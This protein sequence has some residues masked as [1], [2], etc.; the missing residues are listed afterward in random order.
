MSEPYSTVVWVS[1]VEG[2]KSHLRLIASECAGSECDHIQRIG[3]QAMTGIAEADR[4]LADQCWPDDEAD[5]QED[6]S[7]AALELRSGFREED[8][9]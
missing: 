6:L 5:R 8:F 4:Y 7:R 2:L 9:A 1:R 3:R